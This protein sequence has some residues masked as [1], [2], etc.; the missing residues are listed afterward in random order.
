MSSEAARFSTELLISLVRQ[1]P[2]LWNQRSATY[3]NV[4]ARAD[5]CRRVVGTLCLALTDE[6]VKLAYNRW[7]NLRD[8]FSRKLRE[9][10]KKSGAGAV[11]AAPKWKFFDLLLFLKDV[12]EP[13]PTSS[14]LDEESGDAT[15]NAAVVFA[16][17][18]PPRCASAQSESNYCSDTP[19]HTIPASPT[20]DNSNF[21]FRPISAPLLS[22][23]STQPS[24]STPVLS[25]SLTP[26]PLC[27]T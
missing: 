8:T 14:N 21:F 16:S 5:A 27:H 24:T 12:T 2:A 13:R 9:Q 19:D 26:I 22:T 11:E 25:T 15:D 1:E 20:L 10:K 4:D 6:N 7:H 23:L 17:M 18:L 3:R